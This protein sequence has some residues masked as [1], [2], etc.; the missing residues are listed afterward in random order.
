MNLIH[1][2]CSDYFE[3]FLSRCNGDFLFYVFL[4]TESIPGTV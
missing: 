1:S 4:S 2:F 3:F